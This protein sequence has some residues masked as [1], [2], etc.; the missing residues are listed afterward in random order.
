M[1]GPM[2]CSALA[3]GSLLAVAACAPVP[4]FPLPMTATDLV[5]NGTGPALVAYLSQPAA[6]P[7]VCDPEARGP[8]LVTLDDGGVQALVEAFED[9]KIAPDLFRRC[10]EHLLRT[11]AGVPLL[12]RMGGTYRDLVRRGSEV[13]KDPRLE[14]RLS[15]LLALYVERPQGTDPDPERLRGWSAELERAVA[16]HRLG[17]TAARH[18]GELLEVFSLEKNRWNG[19]PVTENTLDVIQN[20]H[21]E[22]LLR[23]FAARLPDPELRRQALRRIVRLHIAAS[24]DPAVR[25][26]VQEVEDVVMK[27]GRNPLAP[28]K[29]PP[30]GGSLDIAHLPI[31]RVLVRQNVGAGTA[32]ILGAKGSVVPEVT[33]RG[34]LQVEMTGVS[35]PVTLCGPTKDLDPTPCLDAS[36]LAIDNRLVSVDRDGGLVFVDDVRLPDLLPLALAPELTVSIAAAGRPLGALHLG[37]WFEKPAD[38]PFPGGPNLVIDVDAG[39][40]RRLVYTIS[41]QGFSYTAVVERADVPSFHIESRGGAGMPGPDGPRGADGAPGLPGTPAAC[42]SYPAGPGGRGGDGLP[43]IPGGFGGPGGRGGDIT[44]RLSCGGQPCGQVADQLRQAI[45]SIGGPG[46]PGGHGGEGGH[47]GNGGLGG[48]GVDCPTRNQDGTQT[49]VSLSSGQN[50]QNGQDGGRGFDGQPGPSGPPGQVI[51]QGDFAGPRP[52]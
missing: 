10:A 39:S 31:D 25:G 15:A 13:D 29:F 14:H 21:E 41:G 50:G 42:P 23:R 9:D 2:R 11:P 48:S 45:V 40:E 12:N 49:S 19:A 47:G 5:R 37:A 33:L 6:S 34:F 8:H 51:V 17:V 30:L 20:R 27:Y 35:R 38:M 3:L 43:G 7:G 22:P 4:T 1:P 18:A 24:S 32:K 16:E 26:H 36:A 52:Q 46:G 44:I 28:D